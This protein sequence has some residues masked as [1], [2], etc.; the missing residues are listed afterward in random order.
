VRSITV[1]RTEIS[2]AKR[3]RQTQLVTKDGYHASPV[4][5]AVPTPDDLQVTL[6]PA[7]SQ[8]I[9][10]PELVAVEHLLGP[11]LQDLLGRGVH[12]SLCPQKEEVG[13][14]KT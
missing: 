8:A 13:H 10:P 2:V 12:D 1:N 5:R 9:I 3:H 4:G 11:A 7:L 14:A 6:A